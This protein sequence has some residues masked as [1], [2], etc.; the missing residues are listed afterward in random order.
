MSETLG[1]DSADGV[2]LGFLC[3][4]FGLV[5][6]LVVVFQLSLSEAAPGSDSNSPISSVSVRSAMRV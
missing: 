3:L 1:S 2:C 5:R 6:T 4:K